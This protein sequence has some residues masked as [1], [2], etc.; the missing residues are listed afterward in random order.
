[1]LMIRPATE[2]D[3]PALVQLHSMVQELHARNAPA[4]FKVLSDVSAC[5]EFFRQILVEPANC[6]LVAEGNGLV[7]GY[8]FAQEVRREENWMCPSSRFFMLEHIAVASVHRR[9]GIGHEL[10]RRFLDEARRRRITR[11]EVVHWSFNAPAAQFFR[12]HGFS[13]MHQRLETTIS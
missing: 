10:I 6:V 8:L 9:K 7:I 5:L 12:Q 3:L 11:V 2:A 13:P 1:M 4:S